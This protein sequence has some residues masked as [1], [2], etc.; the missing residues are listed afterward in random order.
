MKKEKSFDKWTEEEV[1][2][3]FGLEKIE[4]LSLLDDWLSSQYVLPNHK[5]IIIE[6]LCYRL[7]KH[8]AYWTQNELIMYFIAPFLS[9]VDY[10]GYYYQTFNQ[11]FIQHKVQGINM[12]GQVATLLS[13]YNKQMDVRHFFILHYQTVATRKYDGLGQLLAAMLTAQAINK[14]NYT[15]MGCC[16]VGNNWQF[17]VLLGSQYAVSPVYIATNPNDILC[18][19]VALDGVKLYAKQQMSLIFK[20]NSHKKK[21]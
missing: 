19:Y 13:H 8:F 15:L 7:Q 14:H 1:Q 2:I 16:V 6:S 12:H 4:N 9:L 17:V 10:W 21:K 20:Q 11:V 18:I 3:V 5:Q